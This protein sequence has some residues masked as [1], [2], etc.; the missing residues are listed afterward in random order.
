[1]FLKTLSVSDVNA[2]IKKITDKDFILNNLTVKGEISN[3]KLHYS[4]HMYFSIKDEFSRINCVMFKSDAANLTFMPQDG[5]NV[6][7]SGRISVYEKDGSYQL[8]CKIIK[9][10]GEGELFEAYNKLKFQLEQ[11]G[12]FAAEFKKPIP[13]M[14][15]SIGI[16][17]SPTGAAIRDV[18]KVSRRRNKSI[19]IKIYKSLVQGEGAKEEICQGIEYFNNNNP[20]DVIILCRGGGSIEEL[21]AFNEKNVAYSIFK[22]EIPV[23]T[24]IGHE[25]DFTIADFVADYRA[26]TPSAAAEVCTP[27]ILEINDKLNNLK[28]K[29]EKLY[30]DKINA[31]YSN[32]KLYNSILNFN[33]PKAIIESNRN[34]LDSIK[35]SLELNVKQKVSKDMEMLKHNNNLLQAYNPFAVLGKGYTV[36]KG[37]NGEILNQV[38]DFENDREVELILK[39]GKITKKI[40]N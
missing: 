7:I 34:M 14:P 28:H 5:A 40:T 3:F 18:I 39:D 16:V 24:G 15:R 22:S 6:E 11:E 8:Y 4:G 19:D 38:S 30:K 37:S 27:S 26:S 20:V 2:Y 1:M 12:L 33:N 29:F 17:T 10:T 31:E 21:W 32:L 35:N 36:I 13:L 25:T 9:K 23:V